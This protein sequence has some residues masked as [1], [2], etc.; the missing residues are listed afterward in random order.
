MPL[1]TT[2]TLAEEVGITSGALF[3]HFVSREAMLQEAAQVALAKIEA[4]FPAPG[5]PPLERL[6]ALARNRLRVVG[7]DPGVAWVLRSEQ[8]YLSLPDHAVAQLQDLVR[9]SK[10]F[11]ME[12]LR[13]GAAN[14][15]IRADIEPEVLFVPV[16]GTIHALIGMAGVHQTAARTRGATPARVLAALEILLAPAGDA[17]QATTEGPKTT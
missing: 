12:V 9:R 17:R 10:R 5:L 14:G 15:T 13:E 16:L 8:A 7:S 1:L 6:L 11:I 2:T 4:T 3:R